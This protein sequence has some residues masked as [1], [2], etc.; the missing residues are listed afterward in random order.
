MELDPELTSE[1]R[2]R[3]LISGLPKTVR[4]SSEELRIAYAEPLRTIV[5][6]VKETLERTPPEL[7]SDIAA[8]GL[9][10]AG[11]GA[12]LRAFDALLR[13]E[14]RLP[15]HHSESPLTCVVVGA[16]H[17]LEEFEALEGLERS[18]KRRGLRRSRRVSFARRS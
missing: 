14:T 1:V 7:A 16:G 15:V 18:S 3:D 2:G 9:L 4:L 10:L 8:R 12:L 13:G 6:A 17:S 11:G 5:D